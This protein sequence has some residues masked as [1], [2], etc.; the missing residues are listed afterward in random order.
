MAGSSTAISRS[1]TS[2]PSPVSTGAKVGRGVAAS[3]EARCVG[4]GASVASAGAGVLVARTGAG[5]GVLVAAA[6][7]AGC[8]AAGACVAAAGCAAGATSSV[9]PPQP[10]IT[11]VTDNAASRANTGNLRNRRYILKTPSAS[12]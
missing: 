12:G 4:V 2:S 3:T 7:A 6:G 11:A 10:M 1:V 9:A 5:A 8:P